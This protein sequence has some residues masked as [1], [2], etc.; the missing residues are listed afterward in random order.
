M[1]SNEPQGGV[2]NL[3]DWIETNS[4]D[5]KPPVCNKM[6]H[7]TGRLRIMMIGGPNQ[8][9]DFHLNRGEELFV[10]LQ[11][12][13]SLKLVERGT[14]IDFAIPEG[15]LAMTPCCMPH[16]PQRLAN[17]L[18][19]VVER[20][21]APE[22]LDGLRYH[23][24]PSCQAVLWE[25]FFHCEDLGKE[26]V[27][28]IKAFFASEEFKT[29]VPQPMPPAPWQPDAEVTVPPPLPLKDVAVKGSAR[30]LMLHKEFVVDAFGPGCGPIAP[31]PTECWVWVYGAGSA[32][33]ANRSVV[34]GRAGDT[35]LF[36]QGLASLEVQRGMALVIYTIAHLPAETLAGMAC[37][38]SPLLPQ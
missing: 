31:V 30:R 13:A 38:A 25:R 33:V 8:R 11:G 1:A 7:N 6:I 4:G 35:A 12:S 28:L 22:E 36:M 34:L 23:V 3:F 16:S 18:G 29:R 32:A 27:P 19:I 9:Q 21:R 24:D 14:A 5:L 15:T 2:I 10:Q 26:L 17:T 37:V 20:F